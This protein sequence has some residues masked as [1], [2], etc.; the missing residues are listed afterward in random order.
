M[1]KQLCPDITAIQIPT[2]LVAEESGLGIYPQIEI[3]CLQQIRAEASCS[4]AR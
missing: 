4:R 3:A 2:S 1:K